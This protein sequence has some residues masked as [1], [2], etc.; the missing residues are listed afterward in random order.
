MQTFLPY[1]DFKKSAEALDMKR[2]G[3][4][5]VECLQILKALTGAGGWKNHPAVK[6]WNGYSSALIT[7]GIAI[8][9]EWK[10][11]GYKDT[12]LEKILQF[13]NPGDIMPPWMG[14]VDF[15]ISHMSNLIRKDSEYY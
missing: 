15:H 8:C 9:I 14:N 1:S 3:K 6:M 13:G 12:C 7:Y 4:Q 5:R 10:K 2:L 11:R